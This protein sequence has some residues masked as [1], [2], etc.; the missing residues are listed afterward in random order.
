MEFIVNAFTNSLPITNELIDII[1]NRHFGKTNLINAEQMA[2]AVKEPNG[3]LQLELDNECLYFI[4]VFIENDRIK[5]YS[6]DKEAAND[7]HYTLEPYAAYKL[8]Q[9]LEQEYHNGSFV[10]NLKLYFAEK[11][12]YDLISLLQGNNIVFQQFHYD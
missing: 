4:R 12:D 5:S 2:N 11:S 3:G 10:D 8:S 9:L 7:S 1:L 6:I